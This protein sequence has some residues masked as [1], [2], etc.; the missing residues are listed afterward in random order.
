MKRGDTACKTCGKQ[1]PCVVSKKRK[2]FC[3]DCWMKWQ[4]QQNE[5]RYPYHEIRSEADL[6]AAAYVTA[7]WIYRVLPISLP[8]VFVEK[9]LRDQYKDFKSKL[10]PRERV[11]PFHFN[12]WSLAMRKGFLVVK[13]GKPERAWVTELS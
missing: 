3:H 9:R 1:V 6:L 7:P 4:R 5:N 13:E 11:W 12:Q 2:G 10:G 8:A